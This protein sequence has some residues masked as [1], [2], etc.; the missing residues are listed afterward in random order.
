VIENSSNTNARR[1]PTSRKHMTIRNDIRDCCFDWNDYVKNVICPNASNMKGY[2]SGFV[3]PFPKTGNPFNR[4]FYPVWS[5]FGLEGVHCSFR[6][7]LF[8]ALQIE[9]YWTI[10]QKQK[11]EYRKFQAT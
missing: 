11:R 10:K 2:Y 9:I 3:L 7:N 6:L 4:M 8:I 5:M 1:L